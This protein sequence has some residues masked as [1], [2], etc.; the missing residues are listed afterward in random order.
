[1]FVTCFIKSIWRIFIFYQ[2]M[3]SANESGDEFLK[4]LTD[5]VNEDK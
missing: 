4:K 3:K 1:M 5:I 2:T